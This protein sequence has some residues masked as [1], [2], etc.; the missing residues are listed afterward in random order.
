MESALGRRGPSSLAC[1]RER[2]GD[3]PYARRL[4]TATLALSITLVRAAA[5]F[6]HRTETTA[7]IVLIFAACILWAAPRQRRGVLLSG[8]AVLVFVYVGDVALALVRGAED[9]AYVSLSAAVGKIT[10]YVASALLALT[11]LSSTRDRPERDRRLRAIVLAPAIYAIA[12]LVLSEAGF[13]AATTTIGAAGGQAQLLGL[14]GLG[15]S[16]T[17][18]PLATS[19]NLYSI[20]VSCGAAG[21]VVLRVSRPDLLPRLI[22]WPAALVCVYEVLAGDSRATL[23]WAVVIT[24]VFLI[25]RGFRGLPVIAW[26][27]PFFPMIVIG[28]L[29]LIASSGIAQVLSRGNG[30]Q[31]NLGS[32]AT[33]TGRVYIWQGAWSVIRHLRLQ[34]LIGWGAAGQVP[35]GASTHYAF[36]FPGQPL[37]YTVFTHNSSL[38]AILDEG[39]LGLLILVVLLWRTFVLLKRHLAAVPDSPARALVAMLLVIVLSGATEV[40]PSY[41]SEEGLLL[42]LLIGAPQPADAPPDLDASPPAVARPPVAVGV[43]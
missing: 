7:V 5:T 30:G 43:P 20:V 22:A 36:V 14:A 6:P 19:I 15:A 13:H 2:V 11:A 34:D 37:A 9:G 3:V 42:V 25:R 28:L 23:L 35:S 24:A 31:N 29:D 17:V 10:L 21:V 27:L 26:A 4:V 12:N 41:Y 32:I 38:Q 33:G 18:Y 40:S 39:Y 16:R 8:G 1:P